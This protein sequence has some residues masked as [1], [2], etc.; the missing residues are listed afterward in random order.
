MHQHRFR[1]DFDRRVFFA[2]S[3]GRTGDY[4]IHV[5]SAGRR[6][7]HYTYGR[8]VSGGQVCLGGG[9]CGLSS[10]RFL[11][12]TVGATSGRHL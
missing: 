10:G 1:V 4:R 8:S 7:T 12:L 5:A 2:A 3:G 11:D 6:G 9:A